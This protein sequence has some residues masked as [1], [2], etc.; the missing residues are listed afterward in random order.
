[1]AS[2]RKRGNKYH[3]QVR[4]VGQASIT[5]SFLERKDAQAWARLMEVRADKGLLL[6]DPKILKQTTLGEVLGRY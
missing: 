3:V 6:A 1:M 2:I 4:R 5:K